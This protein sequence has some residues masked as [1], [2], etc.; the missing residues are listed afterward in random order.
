[1]G[2]QRTPDHER[3]LAPCRARVPGAREAL[4]DDDSS[5]GRRPMNRRMFLAAA[6][7]AFAAER[8]N[9]APISREPLRVKFSAASPVKLSNGATVLV[10]EDNRLPFVW[11]RI[12]VDG[13]GKIYAPQPGVA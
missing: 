4:G 5:G 2:G 1:M 13:A 3:R 10:I 11:V 12:Q 9:L 6:A 8:K 7:S